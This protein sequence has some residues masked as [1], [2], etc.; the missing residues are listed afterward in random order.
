MS[1]QQPQSVQLQVFPTTQVPPSGGQ[2]GLLEWLHLL[3]DGW[4]AFLIVLALGIGAAFYFTSQQP[5]EFGAT[6]T[7]VVTPKAG[8]LDPDGADA[9]PSLTQTVSRLLSTPA[10]L[11]PTRQEWVDSADDAAERSGRE[12]Q[13]T[14]DWLREHVESTAVG[15]TS[16]IDVRGTAGTQ[17]EATELTQAAVASL[18]T[19]VER[20]GFGPQP[21]GITVKV[22]SDNETQGEV[23]P[24][25][26]RNLLIGVNAGILLGIVAALVTGAIRNG[27]Y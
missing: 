12:S 11:R 3:K 26:L 21:E 24:T 13:A 20:E 1:A 2:G 18:A 8:F 10:V 5:T 7:V 19:V 4:F 14:L 17:E 9:L 16:L 6:G 25:P 23:S 15:Q 27:Y 22:L